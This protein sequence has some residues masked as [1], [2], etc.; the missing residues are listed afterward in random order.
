MPNALLEA[1]A[2][3]LAIVASDLPTLRDI[4]GANERMLL[5]PGDS[6]AEFAGALRRLHADAALR[7]RLA[8]AAESWASAHA[9]TDAAVDALIRV[10]QQVLE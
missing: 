4:A 9:G 8:E 5:V 1:M 10:Y 7:D 2:F 3:G 6:A